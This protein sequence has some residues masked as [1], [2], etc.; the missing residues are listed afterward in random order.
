MIHFVDH[1]QNHA[2]QN[3]H[4]IAQ[5]QIEDAQTYGTHKSIISLTVEF[6]QDVPASYLKQDLTMKY[7]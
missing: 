3:V 4:F 5:Y 6:V 2:W 7:S 1:A